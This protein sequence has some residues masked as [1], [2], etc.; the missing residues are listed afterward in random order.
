MRLP[1]L[2]GTIVRRLLVNFW[3]DPGV[4]RRV[5]PAPLE[6]ATRNGCAVL[7]ICLMRL[8]QLRVQGMPAAEGIAAETMAHRIAIRYPSAQGMKDGVFVWRRDTDCG[9]LAQLG[10]LLFPAD[11][12]R[13]EFEVKKGVTGMSLEA[14]TE[15][16]DADVLLLARYTT[17]WSG[18]P[19]FATVEDAGRFFV[20]ADCVFSCSRHDRSLEGARLRTLAWEVR[21]LE[22]L[23]FRATFFERRDCFP[24]DSIGFDGAVLLHP[25]P[26]GC[27]ALEV[28]PELAGVAAQ[29]TG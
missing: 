10:G 29:Q 27:A 12:R 18:S 7:G 9:L 20:N 6:V 23:D 25:I 26:S 8:E 11:F 14:R 4:V 15:G 28:V 19:L 5:V 22:V 17:R 21:S 13:A 16:G 3:A 1:R 24:P 2:D